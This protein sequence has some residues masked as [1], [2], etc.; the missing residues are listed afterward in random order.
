M[1]CPVGQVISLLDYQLVIDN[2]YNFLPN[3]MVSLLACNLFILLEVSFNFYEQKREVSVIFG[4]G[5][6]WLNCPS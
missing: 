1:L 4:V 2:E 3:H 5:V 6:Q